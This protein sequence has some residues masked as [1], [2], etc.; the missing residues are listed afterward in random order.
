[1]SLCYESEHRFTKLNRN[2]EMKLSFNSLLRSAEPAVVSLQLS[3]SS[4]SHAGPQT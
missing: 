3:T 1:M 4:T 2:R